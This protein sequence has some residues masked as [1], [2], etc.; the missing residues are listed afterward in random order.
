MSKLNQELMTALDQ[1]A[2][3][4]AYLEVLQA[5]DQA[6][7]LADIAVARKAHKREIVGSLEEA[8]NHIPRLLRGPIRKLF[9]V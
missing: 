5:A 4:L 3:E 6:Q 1:S 2:S 8:L 7:L 9:G